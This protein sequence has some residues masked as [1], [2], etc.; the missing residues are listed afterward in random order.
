MLSNGIIRTAA[1]R[2]GPSR[3]KVLVRLLAVGLFVVCHAGAGLVT[4]Q[5]YSVT[6]LGT[7]GGNES[8]AKDI[9]DAGQIV[10]YAKDAAGRDRAFLWQSGAMTDLGTLSGTESWAL[11]IN[12]LGQ[13]VGEATNAAGRSRAFLWTTANTKSPRARV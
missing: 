11:A 6:D 7:L 13:V 5:T 2:H 9:N 4:A 12:N 10:G 8:D 1:R 3:P